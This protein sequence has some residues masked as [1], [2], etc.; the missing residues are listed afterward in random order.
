MAADRELRALPVAAAGDVDWRRAVPLPGALLLT[1][2]SMSV[3]AAV[4]A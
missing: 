2:A 3:F 4:S 1:T